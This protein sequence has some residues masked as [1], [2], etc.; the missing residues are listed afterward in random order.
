VAALDARRR[1]GIFRRRRG[2]IALAMD[3]ATNHTTTRNFPDWLPAGVPTGFMA[4][5]AGMLFPYAPYFLGKTA[6]VHFLAYYHHLT[7][8]RRAKEV[9]EE[10]IAGQKTAAKEYP[11]PKTDPN[12]LDWGREL[13]NMNVFWM[14]A[15]EEMWDPAL[16]RFAREWFDL[17]INREYNPQFT[18]FRRFEVYVY[19]GL[20][21]QQR[22]WKDPKASKVMLQD[23][24]KYGYPGLEDGGIWDVEKAIAC[25][26]A[27]EQTKD[28]RFIR[29]AWDVARALADLVLTD[30]LGARPLRRFILMGATNSIA[31]CSVRSWSDCH[32]RQNT[33]CEWTNRLCGGT[34]FL[35]G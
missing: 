28:D 17:A 7:G 10:V 24:A 34:L 31:T 26:W 14:N 9:M 5:A 6:K 21:L 35:S 20:V 3:V 27:Y 29:I 16:K 25:D 18:E 15:W 13:Y 32:W 4:G 23:L 12:Y 11:L 30:R 2:Y 8:Y 19:N 1:A 33:G 22:F